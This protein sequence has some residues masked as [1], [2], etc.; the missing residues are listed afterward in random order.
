MSQLRR[1]TFL[2]AIAVLG[3]SPQ[4]FAQW[5]QTGPGAITIN[6]LA[7]SENGMMYAGGSVNN[8][9]LVFS[10]VPTTV[11]HGRHAT[12]GCH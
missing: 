12:R 6:A 4:S 11:N 3:I 10:G 7:I 2:F 1:A 8:V 5:T 9:E